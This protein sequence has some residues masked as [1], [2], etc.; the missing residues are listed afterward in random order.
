MKIWIKKVFL[1][2]LSWTLPSLCER[3]LLGA[4]SLSFLL[5]LILRKGGKQGKRK[6]RA[7]K[8]YQILHKKLPIKK[9]L[10][11]FKESQHCSIPPV[12]HITGELVSSKRKFYF[13]SS[14]RAHCV[15]DST[16]WYPTAQHRKFMFGIF[17]REDIIPSFKELI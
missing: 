6:G 10:L 7:Y 3:V 17:G 15:S 14:F 2:P 5:L 11:H 12:W 9:C 8:I 4:Q 16:H 13:S 1:W